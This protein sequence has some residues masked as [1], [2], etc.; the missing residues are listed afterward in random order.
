MFFQYFSQ[1]SKESAN[2]YF[3]DL[4]NES[5]SSRHRHRSGTPSSPDSIRMRHTIA[6][7]DEL[8]PRTVNSSYALK[9]LAKKDEKTFIFETPK[10]VEYPVRSRKPRGLG[11]MQSCPDTVIIKPVDKVP[12]KSAGR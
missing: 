3:G 10:S 8:I 4:F 5:F 7:M 11:R 1:I 12:G 2:S 6:P 9:D